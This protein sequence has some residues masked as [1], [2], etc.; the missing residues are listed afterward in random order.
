[1]FFSIAKPTRCTIFRVYWISLCM[2]RTVLP[3]IIR[4]PRLY[5]RSQVYVIQVRW[6]LVSGPEMEFHFEPASKRSTNLYD[7][8]LTPYVQSWTPDDGWKDRLKHVGWYSIN[9]KNC[10]SS[11]LYYRNIS[12]CTV[13]WTSKT[14]C[15]LTFLDMGGHV[16]GKQMTILDQNG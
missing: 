14:E 12:W 4:S 16:A 11:W 13:P 3:S 10:A 7:I 5:I 9:S 2:F 6:L 1:M 15:Y 8:Y